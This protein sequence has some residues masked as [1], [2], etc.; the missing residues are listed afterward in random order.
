MLKTGSQEKRGREPEMHGPVQGKGARRYGSRDWEV[1]GE[2][3]G[4]GARAGGC[5]GGTGGIGAE[6]LPLLTGLDSLK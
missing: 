3:G 4:K 1:R 5:R 2:T 6:A